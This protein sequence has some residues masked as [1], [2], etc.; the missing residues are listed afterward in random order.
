MP[1][2]KDL[3]RRHPSLLTSGW[4]AGPTLLLL[5]L[6][7]TGCSTLQTTNGLLGQDTDGSPYLEGD[8]VPAQG[9]ETEADLEEELSGLQKL[10]PWEEGVTIGRPATEVEQS[11]NFPLT[12]N[13]QVQYYL[14]LFQNKQHHYFQKWLE[15]STIYLPDIEKEL[16]KSGIPTDLAYLAMIESGFNPLATSPARAVGL[17]QFIASTGRKYNLT[18]DNWLDE[19]RHPKKST[20]AAAAYLA[21]LYDE[22]SDWYLAVAAYN[23]GENKIKQ[24]I[25]KYKTR[26]FWK[27][28]RSHYLHLETKRYVPKL[29]A[30]IL[31][32]RNPAAYGF[33]HL[34]YRRPIQTDQITVAGGTP[35][36]AIAV[37]AK[38]RLRTLRLLNSELRRS[39][40]P[41]NK[42][43]YRINLP[44]GKKELTASNLN[45]LRKREQLAFKTHIVHRGD[46]VGKI[47]RRYH[48][49]ATQLLKANTISN[50]VLRLGQHLRIPY[51]RISYVLEKPE[52]GETL[53]ATRSAT[54][55]HRLRP[56]ETLSEVAQQYHIRLKEL[57]A[58]N[59]IKDARRVRAGTMLLVARGVRR[60]TGN[61][62]QPMIVVLAGHK[63]IQVARTSTMSR[64]EIWY[65]VRSGDSLW[66]IARK[67]RVSTL[68]IK[69]WN[70]LHS[71]TI[72]PGIKLVVKKS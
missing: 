69:K 63:K 17:W 58:T 32:A 2:H 36:E 60:S 16:K 56:G 62:S 49:T 42:K 55:Y 20:R 47:C 22:F 4:L 67:F 66:T 9:I 10:G 33:T 54:P 64:G 18:I 48:I 8:G 39:M 19:R 34:H 68:D 14:D 72:R 46:T 26:D 7:L 30:A 6:V 37:A 35:L 11:D 15:R 71:N 61:T 23:A 24:A 53:V 43:Q 59:H 31:I 52:S 70:Q 25:R 13:R 45:R 3:H 51:R 57:M 40:T 29:I 21:D 5:L 12:L 38:T 50:S 44:P 41:R 28:A 1:A 65:R 27:I